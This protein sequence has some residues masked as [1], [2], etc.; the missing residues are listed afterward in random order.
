MLHRNE[1]GGH[2]RPPFPRVEGWK[3]SE[4]EPQRH[5]NLPRAADGLVHDP[6]AARASGERIEARPY[7][8]KSLKKRFWE[9]LST[10]M[11][12]LG[13]LV[14][15]KTSKLYFSENR[16]VN[17][18]ILTIET[19]AR[20]CQGCRKMLRC[21]VV[22]LVS[23]V[24]PGGIAPPRSPGFKQRQGEAGRIERRG[25]RLRRCVPLERLTECSVPSGTIGLVMP[26]DVP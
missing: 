19:S 5:L 14:R 7:V 16:S 6:Q 26:S 13:V 11:S 10:G 20:F 8:G 4:R 21:P 25:R 22:K 12:K 9:T 1:N 24:S 2:I 3:K 17:F 23:K 18:V 15:L